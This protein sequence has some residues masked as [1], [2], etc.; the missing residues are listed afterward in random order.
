MT[1]PRRS[2][3]PSGKRAQRSSFARGPPSSE[4]GSHSPPKRPVERRRAS[5]TRPSFVATS[6]WT[7]CGFGFAFRGARAAAPR[8]PRR[9]RGTR[10]RP[11]SDRMQ[12][13]AVCRPLRRAPSAP[14]SSHRGS[15]RA[16]A[17]RRALR[18]GA[19]PPASCRPRSR[20]RV[21]APAR[22]F[23]RRARPALHTQCSRSHR[24]CNDRPRAARGDPRDPQASRFDRRR[25]ELRHGA[26]ARADNSRDRSMQRGPDPRV[27]RQGRAASG[28]EP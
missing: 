14:G 4:G 26:S 7:R 13:H 25:D 20:R 21:R 27:L 3:A 15:S 18:R 28:T 11:G 17:P 19:S 22:R 6:A 9:A 16:R 8:G 5:K 1:R 24:R 2:T 12:V 23:R 10:W